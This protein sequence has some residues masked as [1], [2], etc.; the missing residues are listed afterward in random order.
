[1]KKL[2][3][4]LG[5]LGL[6]SFLGCKNQNDSESIFPDKV[7]LTASSPYLAKVTWSGEEG[8]VY[9]L[10]LNDS[11]LVYVSGSLNS[12]TYA[13]RERGLAKGDCFEVRDEGGKSIGKTCIDKT[14]PDI[15]REPPLPHLRR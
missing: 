8:K 13:A 3:I 7:H 15:I 9:Q 12:Y 11:L 5:I 10:F 4:I 2:F 6:L 14:F 1:M